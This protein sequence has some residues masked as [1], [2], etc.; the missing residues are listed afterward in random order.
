MG[1]IFIFLSLLLAVS[2]RMESAT[3]S[4]EPWVAAEPCSF[5]GQI[6]PLHFLQH[7]ASGKAGLSSLW[8]VLI[9]HWGKLY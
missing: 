6:Q 5:P 1:S 9:A 4:A 2:Q 3:S 7:R 8:I